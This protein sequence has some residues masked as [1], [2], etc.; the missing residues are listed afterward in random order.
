MPLMILCG[1]GASPASINL[2]TKSNPSC[3]PKADSSRN[4]P[5][6]SS[7]TAST[8]TW[9]PTC[10]AA[11]A[12][13]DGSDLATL[14]DLSDLTASIS[15]LTI[16]A[17]NAS[18]CSARFA[19]SDATSKCHIFERTL[20]S[21]SS[22]FRMQATSWVRSAI[23]FAEDSSMTLAVGAKSASHAAF[24]SRVCRSRASPTSTC[25]DLTTMRLDRSEEIT[26]QASG[27]EPA[28]VASNRR[29]RLPNTDKRNI[30]L[31][32][33]APAAPL[34]PVWRL[35]P[36]RQHRPGSDPGTSRRT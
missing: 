19:S 32:S 35:S 34:P 26:S 9:A 21:D 36:H 28:N 2:H 18:Y 11:S 3:T 1:S 10:P 7:L 27:Q 8:S 20:A 23:A 30:L 25:S 33:M 31:P 15:S 6:T 29:H 24:H 4:M 16:A 22:A 5:V 17:P 14:A 13:M 12:A